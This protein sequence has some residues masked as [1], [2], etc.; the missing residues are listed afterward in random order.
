[1]SSNIVAREAGG[2][3]E[4]DVG[5]QLRDKLRVNKLRRKS[6]NERGSEPSHRY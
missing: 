3:G 5:G 1:M 2:F 4:K 6:L